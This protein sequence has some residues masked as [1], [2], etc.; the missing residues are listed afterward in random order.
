MGQSATE[1]RYE[2]ESSR[3]NLGETLDAIG[4]RLSP[5]RRIERRRNR[6]RAGMDRFR[7][8]V[9]GTASGARDRVTAPAH[10]AMDVGGEGVSSATD[11]VRDAPD[12]L[13]ERTQGSPLAVG[14]VAAGL[15]FLAASLLP[16]SEKEEQLE[17][18][19]LEKAEPLKQELSDA[20][21]EAMEHLKEPARQAAEQVKVSV[22]ERAA[23]VSGQAKDAAA[24]VAGHAQP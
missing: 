6:M 2:I 13:R 4:D 9:M 17:G 16:T 1:L 23:T 22:E 8:R 24:D 3:A 20:G 15:G 7:D 18:E 10:A 12:M 5:G 21:R 19:L 11:M 14:F